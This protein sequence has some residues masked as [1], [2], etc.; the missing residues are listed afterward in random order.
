MGNID[1][2]AWSSTVQS[3]RDPSGPLFYSLAA[4]VFSA[5]AQP[6]SRQLWRGTTM[7]CLALDKSPAGSLAAPR[8][9]I[10]LRSQVTGRVLPDDA[11]ERPRSAQ[12]SVRPQGH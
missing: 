11:L 7:R 9:V 12:D 1:H 3:P 2:S 8:L 5:L 10:T 6:A 4:A